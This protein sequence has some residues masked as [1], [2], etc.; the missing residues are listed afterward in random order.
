MTW[1]LLRGYGEVFHLDPN[2]LPAPTQENTYKS[3]QKGNYRTFMGLIIT[4][5]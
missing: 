4:H 3:Q 2:H 5:P 1:A